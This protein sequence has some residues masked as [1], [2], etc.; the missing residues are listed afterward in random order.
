MALEKTINLD[1]YGLEL[2]NSYHKID[3]IRIENG[4]IDFVIK[5]FA[6]KVARD[7]MATPLDYRPQSVDFAQLYR[8]HT[9]DDLIAML[10]DYVKR[11]NPEYQTATLDV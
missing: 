5:V 8:E 4:R 3:S 7:Q 2:P 10:Y 9:G 11:V 1:N 6:S